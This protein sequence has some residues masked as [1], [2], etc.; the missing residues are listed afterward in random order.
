MENLKIRLADKSEMK[1]GFSLLQEASLWL[2]EKNIDYWQNWS[3]P[4]DSSFNWIKEGF[5]ANQF[6]FVLKESE[7]VGMFR[8][9]WNDEQFWG[10]QEDNAGYIHS[11]TT[12]RQH[13]G[14]GLGR[15]ILAQIEDM[16]KQNH[17]KYVRLDCG[18]HIEKL[19]Q[20]YENSGFVSVGEISLGKHRLRLYEKELFEE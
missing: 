17:K 2:K 1:K 9:Q 16:C 7:V 4:H 20:Y 14:Q 11:F 12:A 18:A 10:E 19:C 3:N 8:L 5:D 13:Q 15:Q 6:Y